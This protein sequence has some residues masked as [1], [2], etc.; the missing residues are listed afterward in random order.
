M[1]GFFVASGKCS[2][3][4]VSGWLC[5]DRLHRHMYSVQDWTKIFGERAPALRPDQPMAYCP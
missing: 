2:G 3:R 1:E 5:A 4:D